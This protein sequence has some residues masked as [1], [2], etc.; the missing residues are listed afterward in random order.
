L[1]APRLDRECA[2]AWVAAARHRT[3]REVKQWIADRKPK[4]DVTSS[5]RRAP[6]RRSAAEPPTPETSAS[7]GPLPTGAARH[8]DAAASP[9]TPPPR[10][11]RPPATAPSPERERARC[12]PLGAKRYCLRLAIDEEVHEEL[13]E[14]R[15]LLRHQIPDGD[16]AQIVGRAIHVLLEQVR[17]QKTGACFSPRSPQAPAPGSS[18]SGPDAP[19]KRPSRAIPAAI[20]RAVWARDGGRCVYVSRQGRRCGSR[21]FLEYHH[22]VPWDRCREHALANIHLRCRSHNQYAA[23][24]DFGSQHMASFRKRGSALATE[25]AESGGV[26]HSESQVDLNPV[27]QPVESEQEG[28]KMS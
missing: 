2:A 4:A 9:Q 10:E 3:A 18:A 11:S 19:S 7:S 27:K 1:I 24:L 25:G 22:Q 16:V 5:L 14:L 28:T 12:E 13:Q 26:S 21:D 20:R 17:K 23:E 15:A 8:P 6:E